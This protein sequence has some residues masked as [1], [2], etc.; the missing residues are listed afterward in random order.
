MIVTDE[1][2]VGCGGRGRRRS[3]LRDAMGLQGGSKR[4]LSDHRRA[5]ETLLLRT[6]KSCGPD[7]PT[8]VSSL[9]GRLAVGPKKKKPGLDKT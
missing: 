4:P 7:T 3:S 8:L 6:A 9:R 5:D 1:R 2:G